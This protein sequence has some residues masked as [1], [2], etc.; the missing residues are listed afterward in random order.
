MRDLNEEAI[1]TR[2]EI[3]ALRHDVLRQRGQASM[4]LNLDHMK[5]PLEGDNPPLS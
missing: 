2:E 3:Q 4:Q 1:S 5:S